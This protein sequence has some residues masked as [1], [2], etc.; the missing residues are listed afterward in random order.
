[1]GFVVIGVAATTAVGQVQKVPT[2][3]DPITFGAGVGSPYGLASA[4]FL[5]ANGNPGQDGYPEIAVA[6]AGL[7][8]LD[9][10]DQIAVDHSL[11]IFHNTGTWDTNPTGA[12]VQH[13]VLNIA[14]G[15]TATEL[16]F[17]DVTGSGH[18]DLVLL[19]FQPDLGEG[20]VWVYRNLGNG[21][22]QSSPDEFPMDVP[23]RGLVT[24]DLDGDGDID[25]AAAGS[26]CDNTGSATERFVVFENTT[27]NGVLSFDVQIEQIATGTDTAPGDIVVGD[28]YAPSAGDSFQDLVTF[29]PLDPSYTKIR[30][31]GQLQ[32]VPT[33]AAN[34][35]CSSDWSFITAA[36]AKFGT[37]S[38]W[39]FAAVDF[40]DLFLGVFKGNQLAQFTS[41]CDDPA[42]GYQLLPA[43]D[44]EYGFVRAHGIDSGNLNGG[45]GVDLVVTLYELEVASTE[46]PEW[47]S[48]VAVLL[49]KADGTFQVP[50]AQT[51]YIFRTDGPGVV[52]GAALVEV[53]DLD[54]DG[55]D[56][57]VVS[58][59]YSDALNDNFSVLINKM[60]VAIGF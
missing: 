8:L 30:N 13:Q 48:A 59:N 33:T 41:F 3:E 4:D 16:A 12:M 39:D 14:S 19:G 38:W 51:A 20:Y 60:V 37:D 45:P 1:M 22:F 49:G 5:D 34:S 24:V 21:T 47:V 58:N 52:G 53:V 26:N 27:F 50:T 32:F 35:G 29:N 31:L 42:L 36:S 17:A 18:P 7:N 44:P 25:I 15:K 28:F 23:V 55:F 9:N 10:C 57:I 56:D 43:S 54:A 11:K 6:G 46:G 2:F 40:D